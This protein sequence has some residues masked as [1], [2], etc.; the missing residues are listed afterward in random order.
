MSGEA[1]LK[2]LTSGMFGDDISGIKFIFP[3]ST[4]GNGTWYATYKEGV[5]GCDYGYF[6]ECTYD[7]KQMD[8]SGK[9][10]AALVQNEVDNNGIAPSD[11][12][13]AGYSQGGRIVWHTTFGQLPYAIGCTF[14]ITTYPQY[15]AFPQVDASEYSY[16]GADQ[17][18]MM[19]QGEWDYIFPAQ[20]GIDEWTEVFGKL[21]IDPM[22]YQVILEEGYHAEASCFLDVMMDFVRDG[23]VTS[24]EDHRPCKYPP[25]EDKPKEVPFLQ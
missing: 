15:P 5:P 8:T 25:K 2:L 14:G 18:M 24:I 10:L 19:F 6:D 7:M 1:E 13:L 9:E 17:N 4:V 23:K 22:K 21:D 16:Y 20:G 12:F 11:I 3:T